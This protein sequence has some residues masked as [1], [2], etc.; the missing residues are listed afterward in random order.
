MD[1]LGDGTWRDEGPI[2]DPKVTAFEARGME[3]LHPKNL[4][5]VEEE[6]K[7]IYAFDLRENSPAGLEAAQ[8]AVAK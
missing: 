8:K 7:S 6:D 2:S 5:L 1:Q 4:K 3:Q